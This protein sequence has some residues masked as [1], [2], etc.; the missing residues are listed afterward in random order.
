MNLLWQRLKIPVP[1]NWFTGSLDL[2]HS[3][4]FVLPPTGRVPAVVTVHDLSFLRVPQHFVP[5]FQKYLGTAVSRAVARATHILVDSG[6]TGRDLIELLDVEPNRV[7]VVYPGVESRFQPIHDRETLDGVR[8]QY[9]LPRLFILGLSTLQPRK[10]FSGLIAA[11]GKLLRDEAGILG[12]YDDL[13][14]VIAG[15]QGWMYDETLSSVERLGLQDRVHFCGFVA[16]EDLPALYCAASAF[17]FPSW[18]E[19]F[20]LPV[21]EAMACG[22]PVVAA[23][24]SS[25]PEVVGDAGLMVS[26]ADTDALSHALG[27]VLGDEQLRARLVAAG[28]QQARR[29]T[30]SVAASQVLR[31]Y[32]TCA[33]PEASRSK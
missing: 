6:S 24:N 15:G 12:P 5:G 18:Y 25:L 33:E 16:D 22:T 32:H 4:D 30:W 9:G 2:Y 20:G 26:A 29:F 10:N 17:A 14:L 31:A 13:H 23:D 7:T 21:L 27:R 19:G 28:I 8:A 3:P 11:F 1:I